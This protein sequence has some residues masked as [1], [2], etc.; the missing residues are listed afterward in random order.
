MSEVEREFKGM[1]S[2]RGKERVAPKRKI[3]GEE[4]SEEEEPARKSLRAKEDK[5]EGEKEGRKEKNESKKNGKSERRINDRGPSTWSSLWPVA[6]SGKRQSP[7]D[8]RTSKAQ[9]DASLQQTPISYQSAS[10]GS[11]A[12]LSN[13]GAG[14]K[15]EWEDEEGVKLSGGPLG[16]SVRRLKQFHCHWGRD[17][18]RGSEHTVDG[19]PY[20]GE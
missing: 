13:S 3:R 20:A 10:K 19:K 8:I 5:D 14:W 15:V 7:V 17:S 4:R 2:R 18:S 12:K 16:E 6:V 9:E 1:P 11:I